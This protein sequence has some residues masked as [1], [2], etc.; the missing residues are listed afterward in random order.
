[1]T[2]EQIAQLPQVLGVIGLLVGA[3]FALYKRW[4]VM[5]W[6]FQAVEEDRDFWRDLALG[7]L[8][9]NDKAISVAEKGDG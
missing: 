5:G 3:L 1:M 4:V 6:S 8:K 2:A 9:V 7:L